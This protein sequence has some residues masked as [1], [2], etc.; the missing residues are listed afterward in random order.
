[1]NERPTHNT[2]RPLVISA[3]FGN[4]IQPADTTPT[5]GTF[6]R[7]RRRGR[8]WRILKTVRR[9]KRLGAW[10]NRIGLRN[11]GLDWL[12]RRV[13]AGKLDVAASLVSIHGFDNTEWAELLERVAALHPLGI[14]L[15]MSCPNVG[16]VNW[17]EDLFVRAHGVQ[18]ERGMLIVVKLPPVRFER[19]A[20]D[21]LDA[22]LRC[23]HCCNTLPVP[24]GGLSGKPLLPLALRCIHDVRA[25]AGEADVRIIGGGGVTCTQDID[26]YADADVRHVALGTHVFHPRFLFS[27][28]SL[29]PLIA[30]ANRRLLP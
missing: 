22:G 18:R 19:L 15:N 3:P 29:G 7:D 11:P 14:E 30:H 12:E 21:A 8:V 1:V 26:A 24:A 10:V 16:E 25:L 13:R 4:Y 6:T 9:Y 20:R 27:T 28:S 5:I 2:P 23:F 17:P